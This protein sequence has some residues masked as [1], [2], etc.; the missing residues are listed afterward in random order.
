MG[1][2]R[3]YSLFNS[4]T[5]NE[6]SIFRYGFLECVQFLVNDKALQC[7]IFRFKTPFS[8]FIVKDEDNIDVHICENYLIINTRRVKVK[9]HRELY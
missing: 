9:S 3:G 1:Q 2:R 5:T 6:T 4:G 8:C 7:C